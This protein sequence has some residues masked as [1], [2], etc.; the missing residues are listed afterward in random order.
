MENHLVALVKMAPIY[1]IK[2]I[3]WMSKALLAPELHQETI[4][5][6]MSFKCRFCG[7]YI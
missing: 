5:D 2:Y 1:E 6:I 3:I 7:N 4:Y